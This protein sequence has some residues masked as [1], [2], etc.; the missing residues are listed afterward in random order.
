MDSAKNLSTNMLNKYVRRAVSNPV[1]DD[2]ACR[3]AE[4]AAKN[5]VGYSGYF[6]TGSEVNEV[7]ENLKEKGFRP[8]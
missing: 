1:P 5:A 8:T 4:H 6:K 7:V 2:F 3:I